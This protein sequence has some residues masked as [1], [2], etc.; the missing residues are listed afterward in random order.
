MTPQEMKIDA[1]ARILADTPVQGEMTYYQWLVGQVLTPGVKP[2][3]VI[4]LVEATILEMAKQI[5][6]RSQTAKNAG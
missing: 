1:M 3:S 6:S 5:V 2:D 4:S